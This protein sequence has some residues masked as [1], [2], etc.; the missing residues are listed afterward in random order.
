MH[1]ARIADALRDPEHVEEL[2]DLYGARPADSRRV[3]ILCG[4]EQSFRR[5][6]RHEGGIGGERG[7][8][9]LGGKRSL[10]A[11]ATSAPDISPG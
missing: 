8:G 11:F 4:A 2:Q 1:L 6:A 5:R 7:K 9:R 10:N 3:A